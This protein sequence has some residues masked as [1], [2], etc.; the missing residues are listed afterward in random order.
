MRVMNIP[1]VMTAFGTTT[2]AVETY[3]FMNG[4]ISE[5]FPDH[6]ILWSYSSRI[7]K[8]RLKK[9]SIIAC[10]H[11]SQ[12]LSELKQRGHEWVV[13]QSLHLICGHEFYRLVEEVKSSPARTSVGLPLLTDPED[14]H[15]VVQGLG[16]SLP[17]IK[18]EAIVLVG[19]GT[20]HPAWTS[21][22]ALHHMFRARLGPRVFFGVVEGYPS[23]EETILNVQKAGF[24]KARLIPFM[25]VA[26]AH[27]REDLAGD[28]DSWKTGLEKKDISVFLQTRGLGFNKTVIDI[29][30]N[31]IQDALDVI[32][33]STVPP[34]L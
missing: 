34:L 14:Y 8:D 15:R 9:E 12:A 4:R 26:G 16:N 3:S 22:V 33:D 17:D 21:Y 6:E 5:R 27:F 2:V 18:D 32:P 28:E 24:K 13:V 10:K 25:L 11:P 23:R 31:H 29:F 19:H 20:D 7:V 30:C 1:I